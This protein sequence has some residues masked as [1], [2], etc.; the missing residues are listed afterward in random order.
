MPVEQDVVGSS[1][2][3]LPWGPFF[4]KFT[5]KFGKLFRNEEKK[6]AKY[7]KFNNL[8]DKNGK[9]APQ[10]RSLIPIFCLT[11]RFRLY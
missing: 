9:R 6:A 10:L 11:K 1:P 4:N 8:S 3:S 2:T 7:N 5:S